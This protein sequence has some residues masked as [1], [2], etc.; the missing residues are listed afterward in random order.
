M[1][2]WELSGFELEIGVVLMAFLLGKRHDFV[3]VLKHGQS[4]R[5]VGARLMISS[6]ISPCYGKSL[7]L[8]IKKYTIFFHHVSVLV[9]LLE[10]TRGG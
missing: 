7:E 8:K 10:I 5:P 3:I 2:F 4:W 6:Q 1:K 9:P